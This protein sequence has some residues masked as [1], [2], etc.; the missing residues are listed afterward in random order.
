MNSLFGTISNIHSS[1][2]MSCVEINV[3]GA[4]VKTVILEIPATLKYLRVDNK[5]KVLFKETEVIVSREK[6]THSSLENSLTGKI[7]TL[8]KGHLL[9]RL[10]I[11]TAGGLIHSVITTDSSNQMNLKSGDAVHA[12]I[13]TIEVMLSE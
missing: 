1:D 3:S 5:V 13:N 8:E 12:S 10:E 6:I 2:Y 7:L 9:T 4:I 11:E